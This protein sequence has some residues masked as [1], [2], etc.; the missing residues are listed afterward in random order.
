M[1]DEQTYKTIQEK[2]SLP[3]YERVRDVLEELEYDK[4]KDSEQI[5]IKKITKKLVTK[6]EEQTSILESLLNPDQ[7]ISS[8]HEAAIFTEKEREEISNTFMECMRVGREFA[9]IELTQKGFKEYLDRLVT[10]REGK[11]PYLLELHKKIHSSWHP[12]KELKTD[13]EYLG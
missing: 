1:I 7:T 9:I 5:V 12:R 8:M 2:H 10:F 6:L 11:K 4:E 3:L 13:I